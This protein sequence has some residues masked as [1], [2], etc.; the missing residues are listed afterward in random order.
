M[1]YEYIQEVVKKFSYQFPVVADDNEGHQIVINESYEN[2]E[3]ENMIQRLH[4]YD[5]YTYLDIDFVKHNRYYE[6][7][8]ISED[9]S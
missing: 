9:F 3:I 1:S 6:N 8:M 2:V 5:V 4:V 7:G